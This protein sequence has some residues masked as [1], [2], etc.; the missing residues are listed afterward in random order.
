M[1]KNL[2]LPIGFQFVE[3]NIV[4][5]VKRNESGIPEGYCK[6]CYYLSTTLNGNRFCRRPAPMCTNLREDETDVVFV[7]VGEVKYDRTNE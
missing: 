5:E 6:G 3:E 1:C 2:D 4:L 7:K